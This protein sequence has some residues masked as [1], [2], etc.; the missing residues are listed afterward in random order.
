LAEVAAD[1]RRLA[2]MQDE[3]ACA[4]PHFLWS[5]VYGSIFGEGPSQD[6]FATTM[7]ILDQRRIQKEGLVD[8]LPL[9]IKSTCFRNSIKDDIFGVE[10]LLIEAYRV[11]RRFTNS[12]PHT[13]TLRATHTRTVLLGHLADGVSMLRYEA[14]FLFSLR[15]RGSAHRGVAM[16]VPPSVVPLLALMAS[17]A[18]PLVR[19]FR[20]VF[21]GS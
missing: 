7:W 14:T 16:H 19:W 1:E 15:M 8:P 9:P 3:L 6:A 10:H 21:D 12:S 13:S 5:S 17:P 2:H 11:R 18:R 4:V 20:H